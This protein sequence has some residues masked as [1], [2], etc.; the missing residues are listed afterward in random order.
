M[1]GFLNEKEEVQVF[2]DTIYIP[3]N[4]AI[5][6]NGPWEF[7]IMVLAAVILVTLLCLLVSLIGRRIYKRSLKDAMGGKVEKHISETEFN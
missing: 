3:P 7:F 4:N 5:Y 1:K 6:S 2:Y